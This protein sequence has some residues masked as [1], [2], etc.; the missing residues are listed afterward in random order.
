MTASAIWKM[1][2]RLDGCHELEKVLAKTQTI[3]DVGQ[4]LPISQPDAVVV[5]PQI[6]HKSL[7]SERIQLAETKIEE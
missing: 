3:P 7:D 1:N 5:K 4:Q 2:I 6:A